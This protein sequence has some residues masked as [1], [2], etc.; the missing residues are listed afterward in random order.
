MKIKPYMIPRKF[1]KADSSDG[2]NEKNKTSI[3]YD[4]TNNTIYFN[5]NIIDTDGLLFE[6]IIALFKEDTYSDSQGNEIEKEPLRELTMS[7]SSYGGSLSASLSIIA[8][9]DE[10]KEQGIKII[11][12]G[13]EKCM[14]GAC[15]LLINGNERYARKYTDIMFHPALL[16]SEG[17]D[18]YIGVQDLRSLM[19]TFDYYWD[20]MS[21]MLKKKTKLTDKEIKN[22]YKHGDDYYLTV[23]E[24]IEKGFIDKIL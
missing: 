22:I 4:V 11:T 12:I 8:Q 19:K 15:M 7:L 17:E 10:L 21:D 3:E 9:M 2:E 24:A 18:G 23:D 20:I 14:S 16:K 5:G 6:E 13:K 1:V